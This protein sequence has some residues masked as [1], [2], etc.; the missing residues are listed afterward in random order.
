MT[1]LQ[2]LAN[3]FDIAADIMS[4]YSHPLRCGSSQLKIIR[5]HFYS[6]SR[7]PQES[8]EIL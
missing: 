2:P 6:D 4:K 1:M 8:N 7:P 3:A 5:S